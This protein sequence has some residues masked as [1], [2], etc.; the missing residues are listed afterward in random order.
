MIRQSMAA[1]DNTIIHKTRQYTH[2]LKETHDKTSGMQA[3]ITPNQAIYDNIKQ[4][5]TS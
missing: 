4:H 3:N 5:K 2:T 1:Q